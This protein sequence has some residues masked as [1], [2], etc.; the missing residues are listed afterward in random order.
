VAEESI[1]AQS[2]VQ[3]GGRFLKKKDEGGR[4]QERK[5]KHSLG[6]EKGGVDGKQLLGR[7]GQVFSSDWRSS[8]MGIHIQR[9][10]TEDGVRERRFEPSQGVDPDDLIAHQSWNI[11]RCFKEKEGRREPKKW[12]RT[13]FRRGGARLGCVTSLKIAQKLRRQFVISRGP[14]KTKLFLERAED[15][16]KEGVKTEASLPERGKQVMG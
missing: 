15:K 3:R 4:L 1:I 8:I 7:E 11:K 12:V 6:N 5:K 16:R 9:G 14:Q 10:R 13:T 2:L